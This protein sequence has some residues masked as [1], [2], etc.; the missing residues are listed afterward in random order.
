MPGIPSINTDYPVLR[1]SPR[2]L[3]PFR[4][5]KRR[6][7]C[8][9]EASNSLF[10]LHRTITPGILYASNNEDRKINY[11]HY[12]DHI[13][14]RSARCRQ[15]GGDFSRA[16]RRL[17]QRSRSCPIRGRPQ[18]GKPECIRPVGGLSRSRCGERPSEYRAFQ[19]T[20]SRRRPAVSAAAQ[21]ADSNSDLTEVG[22]MNIVTA[23]ELPHALSAQSVP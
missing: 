21:C 18:P 17:G 20:R 8:R 16:T 15:S 19:A 1:D 11:D 13:Y 9:A 3:L 4:K 22:S 14:V 6:V 7:S 2:S 5:C 10:G 23:D 12:V